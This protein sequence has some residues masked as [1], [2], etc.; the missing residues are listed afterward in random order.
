MGR[1]AARDG[2]RRW[3][4]LAPIALLVMLLISP[5][6]GRAEPSGDY[7]PVLPADALASGCYPLPA[8]LRIDFPY[9]VRRDGDVGPPARRHRRLV[10]QYDLVGP[11]VVRSR[12]AA[13]LRR[14]GLPRDAATVTAYPRI[15]SDSVVRGQVVLRLPVARRES[16]V[17]DPTAC[18]DPFTTKRFPASWQPSTSYA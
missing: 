8:G 2:R 18:Y 16:A 15:P 12:L 4:T 17:A 14:A 11:G 10:L 6:V 1:T 5:H 3:W 9:Q 7:R 13:A